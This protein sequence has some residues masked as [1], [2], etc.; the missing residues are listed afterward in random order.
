LEP[1]KYHETT[2]RNYKGNTSGYNKGLGVF[3]QNLKSTRNRSKNRQNY[4]K[5]KSTCTAKEKSQQSEETT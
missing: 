2:K 4:I 5:L 3:E 1:L